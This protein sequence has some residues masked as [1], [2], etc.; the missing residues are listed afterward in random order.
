MEKEL[1]PQEKA[2]EIVKK[3]EEIEIVLGY[4]IQRAEAVMCALLQNE[5]LLEE[6]RPEYWG[7][8]NNKAYGRYKYYEQIKEE[9]L[10]L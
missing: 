6:V 1:T 4:G 8:E 5:A 10:K 3:Y 9:L 7:S 2:I